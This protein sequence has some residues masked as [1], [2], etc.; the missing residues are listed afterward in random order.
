MKKVVLK[1]LVMTAITPMIIPSYAN[2]PCVV[3]SYTTY[4]QKTKLYHTNCPAR[5]SNGDCINTL[6]PRDEE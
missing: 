5:P 4:N 6:C 1:F 3:A 2:N